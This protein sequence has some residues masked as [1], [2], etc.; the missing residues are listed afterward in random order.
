MAILYSPIQGESCRQ[1]PTAAS[2]ASGAPVANDQTA[3]SGLLRVARELQ[4]A[5]GS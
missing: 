4:L 3:G 5:A 2:A 1:N